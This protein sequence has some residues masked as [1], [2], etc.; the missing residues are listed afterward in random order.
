MGPR[1]RRSPA[2]ACAPRPRVRA[3]VFECSPAA[4]PGRTEGV[5][6]RPPA[7][8]GPLRVLRAAIRAARACARLLPP[9]DALQPRPLVR[10]RQ[11]AAPARPPPEHVPRALAP[12][13]PS[14][15]P[16]PVCRG[17]ARQEE[18]RCVA[19]A[20]VLRRRA[21]CV[22]PPAPARPPLGSR[23]GRRARRFSVRLPNATL[24]ADVPA[25]RA[26]LDVVQVPL[27]LRAGGHK[28]SR[29][30]PCGAPPKRSTPPPPARESALR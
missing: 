4:S 12:A 20:P 26:R 25:L 18:R 19:P 15:A 21:E 30:R 6:G 17:P 5:E 27:R 3:R 23:R 11:A 24:Q 8:A 1:A 16:T 9:S 28:S 29:A 14:V 22:L 2:R 13:R 7:R 10:G